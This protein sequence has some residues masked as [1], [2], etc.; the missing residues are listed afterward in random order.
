MEMYLQA[1][2]DTK[3]QYTV[4]AQT[5]SHGPN[6]MYVALGF[7]G[8]S[9][10]KHRNVWN[11]TL[12]PQSL[13]WWRGQVLHPRQ[14]PGRFGL[15]ISFLSISQLRLQR[16]AMQRQSRARFSY[17]RDGWT[18]KTGYFLSQPSCSIRIKT[19]KG[20]MEER[21]RQIPPDTRSCQALN[22]RLASSQTVKLMKLAVW[23][24]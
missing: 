7:S 24:C 11:H 20:H 18:R 19:P 6:N 22:V 23:A 3:M 9:I 8:I 5:Y 14:D 1:S 21:T 4:F 2:K 10:V 15:S 13:R 16:L 12:E 17:L